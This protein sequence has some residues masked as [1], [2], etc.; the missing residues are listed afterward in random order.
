MTLGIDV[1]KVGSFHKII[2]SFSILFLGY[3]GSFLAL[4]PGSEDI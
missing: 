4:D 1:S 3:I 2:N